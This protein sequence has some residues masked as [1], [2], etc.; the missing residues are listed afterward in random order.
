MQ[1]LKVFDSWINKNSTKVDTFNKLVYESTLDR[2]DPT[3]P[4]SFY[5]GKTTDET[6]PRDM[7]AIRDE[8]N[9]HY[10]RVSDQMVKKYTRK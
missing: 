7:Q 2:V 3:K 10:Y 6:A 5:K 9:T 4:R 8:L 1:S